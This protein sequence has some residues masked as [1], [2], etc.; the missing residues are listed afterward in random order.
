VTEQNEPLSEREL[1]ILRL[2]ATGAANKEIAYRLAISPNTVKVHLRN[3][4]SKIG[5]ASRTE[6]TLYAIKIGLVQPQTDGQAVVESAADSPAPG[7][8]AGGDVAAGSRLLSWTRQ[9]KPWQWV[10]GA[11]I[12]LALAAA[13]FA[14]LRLL[15]SAPS[16]PTV[17]SEAVEQPAV[18]S[19]WLAKAAL[20]SPRKGMGYVEYENEFYLVAGESVSGPDGALLRYDPAG[21]GWV[22]LSSKPTAAA[23]IQA[24]MLGERIYVPGGRLGDGSATGVLEVYDPRSDSWENKASLPV[25][26]WGYALASYEGQL[27]L[28]G[29]K[30]EQQAV[31]TVYV[32]SPQE[33]R[34]EERSPMPSARAYANAVVVG[35]KIH[36]LGGHD[37]TAPLDLN[38]AYFPTRDDGGDPAWETFAPL[39]E[40]RYAMSSV[41]MAGLVFVLGGVDDG[42]GSA[43]TSAALYLSQADRWAEF[44]P[45]PQPAGVQPA[46]LASG[47]FIYLLGGKTPSGVTADHQAYQAIFTLSVP[48]LTSEE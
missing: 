40:P 28:F 7:T 16:M 18:S 6:A 20:P 32:Y 29:G 26:L 30:N 8:V 45:P 1:E 10:L 33:D 31:S 22:S 5:V 12:L 48:F 35:N 44:D 46:L 17:A 34:W 11:V 13:S 41:N 9:V 21:D 2:V 19:R 27:F 24:A 14:S 38:E 43:A 39:P 15:A 36:L 42:A 3:I 47:N 25:P 4:F 23:D 37:G